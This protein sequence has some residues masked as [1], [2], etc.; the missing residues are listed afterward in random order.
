MTPVAVLP[1]ASSAARMPSRLPIR[2]L[3]SIS[4][5]TPS[6]SAQRLQAAETVVVPE[7]GP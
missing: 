1:N 4:R 3:P 6:S 5:P 7:R 2:P